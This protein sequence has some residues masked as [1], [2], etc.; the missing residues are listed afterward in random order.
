M[1]YPFPVPNPNPNYN[2]A[3]QWPVLVALQYMLLVYLNIGFS[4]YCKNGSEK[5]TV[6]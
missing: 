3:F 5:A 1:K 6:N 4:L 2:G